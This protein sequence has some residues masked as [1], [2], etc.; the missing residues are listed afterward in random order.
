MP[1]TIAAALS[2]KQSGR[3]ALLINMIAKTQAID[4]I[5]MQYLSGAINRAKELKLDIITVFFHD[6]GQIP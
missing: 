1:N 6:T 4:E 3:V 2:S 5:D